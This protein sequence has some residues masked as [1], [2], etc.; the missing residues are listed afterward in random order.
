M[1]SWKRKYNSNRQ[2]PFDQKRGEPSPTVISIQAKDK[3]A[4]CLLDEN[5]N[6]KEEIIRQWSSSQD[7]ED[8]INM[9]TGE[10]SSK[11]EIIWHYDKKGCFSVKSVYRLATD[12]KA[13]QEAS[14]S[15]QSK[16]KCE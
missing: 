1:A 8:I 2:R 3:R 4:N 11:D 6:W 5:N 9:P 13:S 16:S 12:I 15:D 10:K 14:Q 7:V